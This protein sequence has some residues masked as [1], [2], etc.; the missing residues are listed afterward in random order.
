MAI[1]VA[2]SVAVAVPLSKS[3]TL[4]SIV[5]PPTMPRIL[6]VGAGAAGDEGTPG[7]GVV[8]TVLIAPH[9]TI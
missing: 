5:L 8:V 9:I 4:I 3:C 1:A 2:I 7:N 6:S